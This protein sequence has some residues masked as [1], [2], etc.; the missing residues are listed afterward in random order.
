MAAHDI[1][2]PY[3]CSWYPTQPTIQK[4]GMTHLRKAVMYMAYNNSQLIAILLP[5]T[6]AVCYPH[7]VCCIQPVIFMR[8]SREGN[9]AS[10]K[11]QQ[12]CVWLSNGNPWTSDEL[13]WTLLSHLSCSQPTA[14]RKRVSKTPKRQLTDVASWW[15][16]NVFGPFSPLLFGHECAW[17]HRTVDSL[18]SLA[19]W[20]QP[21]SHPLLKSHE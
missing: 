14:V 1:Q 17:E 8:L 12:G 2:Q 16:W 21:P 9:T 20:V 19:L 11:P 13:K 15:I 7:G 18:D 5:R 3:E 4:L 6:L 10:S